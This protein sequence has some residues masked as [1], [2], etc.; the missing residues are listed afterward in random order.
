MTGTAPPVRLRDFPNRS[1]SLNAIRLGLATCVI[2]S[3][4]WPIGGFGA[5]PH[6]GRLDLG[7]FAVAGFFAISGWLIAQSRLSSELASYSWRRFLRIYPGYLVS[8]LVVAFLVA[9]VGS[10]LGAGPYSV[11][12][13]VRHVVANLTMEIEEF[14]VGGTP[15]GVPVAGA[16]N[17]SL[18]TLFHEA[19]CYVI[20][21]LLVTVLG[22]RW[23]PAAVIALLVGTT[24][25]ELA[26]TSGALAVDGTLAWFL[27]LAPYFFA[28][29]TL[30][31]LRDVLPL[32]GARGARPR[33]SG[34]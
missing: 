3:H 32:H 27:S 14:D 25:L 23:F 28:G 21:G 18:W 9:P 6:W 15:A 4:A 11:G 16:W 31:V 10:L 20:V 12:D 29:A 19:A 22:R 5:D 13:G 1:N 34:S 8:L 2:V 17:G 24:A 30:F 26:A 33:P 7:H